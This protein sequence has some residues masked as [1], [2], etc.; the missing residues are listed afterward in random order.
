MRNGKRRWW[1]LIVGVGE[2]LLVELAEQVEG[3]EWGEVED[4]EVFELHNGRVVDVGGLGEEGEL[5]LGGG[6]MLRCRGRWLMVV[7]YPTGG[8]RGLV[9]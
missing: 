9:G 7:R 2:G 3:G 1:E 8:T 4:V 5:R 6:S